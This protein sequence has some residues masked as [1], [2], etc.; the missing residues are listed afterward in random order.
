MAEDTQNNRIPR[1]I[2][3]S[4]RR[5]SAIAGTVLA[6]FFTILQTAYEYRT[7]LTRPEDRIREIERSLKVPLSIAI[8]PVDQDRLK[9]IADQAL[10]ADDIQTI[11]ILNSKN[12]LLYENMKVNA[13]LLDDTFL[14]KRIITL[15]DREDDKTELGVA[16]I[17][18]T[19]GQAIAS[20]GHAALNA[21]VLNAVKITAIIL[22][23]SWFLR[24]KV[25]SPLNRLAKQI[26][27]SIPGEVIVVQVDTGITDKQGENNE[28]ERVARFISEREGKLQ[29]LIDDLKTREETL[30]NSE[31]HQRD[32]A[33]RLDFIMRANKLGSWE[34]NL[35]SGEA[36]YNDRFSE[37][38]G[39]SPKLTHFWTARVHHDDRQSFENDFDLHTRGWSE[40]INNIHR[41]RHEN[42]PW[43]WVLCTGSAVQRDMEQRA[44]RIVG[45]NLDITDLVDA[46]E[47]ALAAN[48]SKSA[49][50][51]NMSHEIRTPLNGVLGMTSLLKRTSL[52]PMQT[53][54]IKTIEISGKQLL[55]VISD[56]LDLSKVEAGKFDLSPVKMSV[57]TIVDNV[58]RII[59]PSADIKGL[60][61]VKNITPEVPESVYCD[62][63]RL[64]QVL[65]NLASNAVKFTAHG[66]VFIHVDCRQSA[67]YKD[68]VE[69][70]FHIVDE[71]IGIPPDQ[72]KNLFQ[73]FSQADATI[74][75]R[76]GGTGL[77]LAI[78]KQI[79]GLMSGKI[80]V[81]SEVNRGSD[82]T[83]TIN[84]PTVAAIEI[85]APTAEVV[86]PQNISSLLV[87]ANIVTQ[88][89]IFKMLKTLGISPAVAT[90]G[91][92][93]THLATSNQYDIIFMDLVMP[94][95][96]GHEATRR[97]IAH[98]KSKNLPVPAI[99]AITSTVNEGLKERL[100]ETGFA[101]VLEKP[102][103]MIQLSTALHHV[104]RQSA[105]VKKDKS[106]S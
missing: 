41:I 2:E 25:I 18:I 51:A 77:G 88:K 44:T 36:K 14:L 15:T 66:Q 72:L 6:I 12:Q 28:I 7:D 106:A 98:A 86:N 56:I 81:T 92:E 8:A 82:F 78:S 35:H 62:D 61:L 73:A 58:I 97:I 101:D 47:S 45:T 70:E 71:G 38:I 32:L 103:T 75:R 74:T 31:A 9:L 16:M 91:V 83:F 69:I 59:G 104:Q 21:L 30:R 17:K 40:S 53:E 20:L 23:I 54:F 3:T 48:V 22:I 85:T 84:V 67:K 27:K 57:R 96:D 63:T 105:P 29:Q 93:A 24:R 60:S 87:K 68:R 65:V 55:G 90:N 95:M 42:G 34:I 89:V 1:S 102:I 76:Y 99:I 46:R 5:V 94:E 39:V 37:M 13:K 26:K 79:V 33:Q 100:L 49:F 10:L 11:A 52:D 19:P 43:V 4:F 80:G 64:Q 50:L